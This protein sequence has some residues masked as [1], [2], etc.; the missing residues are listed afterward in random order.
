V[1]ENVKQDLLLASVSGGTDVCTAFLGGCPILPVYS[2]EL[3]CRCLG[4]KAEAYG[5]RGN[6]L[7]DEVGELVIS[8][9]MPS[10]PL[11]FWNDTDGNRYRESYFEM[12]PG[13]WRHGDWIRVTQRGG[14]IIYGRSD[15]TINRYGVRVGSSE[16]YRAIE[17]VREISDGLVVDLE[18]LGGSSEMLLFVS[19]QP[20]VQFDVDLADRIKGA[21][22]QHLSPATR[23]RSSHRR[24]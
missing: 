5:E 6:S 7:T 23:T 13:R 2:G 4:V 22:R 16:I 3:Q 20:G 1:Y 11:Y 9:P 15:S 10:M 14:A 24:S 21:I 19:L 8:E 18:G 17:D 12:Y